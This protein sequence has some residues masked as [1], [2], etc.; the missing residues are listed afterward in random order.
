MN[1]FVVMYYYNKK[2]IVIK[3]LNSRKKTNKW[4][5]ITIDKKLIFS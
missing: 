4:S 2:N 5:I 1:I 3:I